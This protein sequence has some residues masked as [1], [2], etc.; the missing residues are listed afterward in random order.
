M[1]TR[2]IVG[3]GAVALLAYLL[4]R[5]KKGVQLSDIKVDKNAPAP[6]TPTASVTVV[7]SDAPVNL[8][9]SPV[10]IED[11]KVPVKRPIYIPAINSI[12]NVYDRGVGQPLDMAANA[13][14]ESFYN[15]SGYC[16]ENLQNACRCSAARTGKYTLDIPQLP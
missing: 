1:K 12:P 3:L 9:S 16:S 14:K 13:S 15:M 4:L 2:T 11:I 7:K 5:K 8:K 10:L 6:S